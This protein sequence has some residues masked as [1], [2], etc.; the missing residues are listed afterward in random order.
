MGSVAAGEDIRKKRE[1]GLTV[2]D[3]FREQLARFPRLAGL[4]PA[5]GTISPYVTSFQCR[6]HGGLAG[7]NWLIVGEAASMV[8]PMTSNGVTAALRHASE[9]CAPVSYTHLDVYK[10]Q[11]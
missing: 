6:V 8:D 2:E 9:A 5:A 11:G 10:R 7:P 3:I 4:L 1:Q